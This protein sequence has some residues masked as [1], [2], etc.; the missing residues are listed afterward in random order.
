VTGINSGDLD[1]LLPLYE[2][3]AAFASQPGTRTSSAVRQT[4]PGAS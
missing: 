4:A 1:S 2:S 3:D